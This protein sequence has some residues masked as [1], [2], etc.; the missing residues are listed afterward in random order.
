MNF[1]ISCFLW[2]PTQ[3]IFSWVSEGSYTVFVYRLA[4]VTGTWGCPGKLNSLVRLLTK[5]NELFRLKS[6]WCYF[7]PET[8]TKLDAG[9]NSNPLNTARLS[10]VVHLLNR[11]SVDQFGQALVNNQQ[12]HQCV[13]GNN[14]VWLHLYTNTQE[15]FISC[16]SLNFQ[17]AYQVG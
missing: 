9:L 14:L 17:T 4:A 13:D 2:S 10:T 11:V 8:V 16:R 15:T 3:P 1:A 12:N 6:I 5:V 7:R